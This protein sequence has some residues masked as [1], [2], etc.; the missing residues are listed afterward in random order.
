MMLAPMV[1]L[2]PAAEAA[3]PEYRHRSYSQ[4]YPEHKITASIKAF[5]RSVRTT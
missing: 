4:R 2:V 3:P 1:R 5:V